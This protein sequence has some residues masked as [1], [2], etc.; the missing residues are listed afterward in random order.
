MS[1]EF[2]E[3]D[4]RL[5]WER[6]RGEGMPDVGSVRQSD[7]MEL[8]VSGAELRHDAVLRGTPGRYT[9]MLDRK[10][11]WI[12][13]TFR[14]LIPPRAGNDVTLEPDVPPKEEK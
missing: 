9:V 3:L 6:R 1:Q 7:G 10:G 13:S 4:I 5:R 11:R 2:P 14:I 12:D 8:G